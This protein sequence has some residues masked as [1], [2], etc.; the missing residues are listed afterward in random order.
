MERDD[1]HQNNSVDESMPEKSQYNDA[2]EA[3]DFLRHNENGDEHLVVDEKKLVRR[4]DFMI[5]PI[6]F[7]CYFLQYLDKSLCRSPTPFW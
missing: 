4:I 2:D 7:A 5:V 1:I 3:L 6:M